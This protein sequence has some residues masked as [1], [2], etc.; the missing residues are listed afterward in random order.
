[1]AALALCAVAQGAQAQSPAEQPAP[2]EWSS[3]SRAKVT[4][5]LDAAGPMASD[6]SS[7]AAVPKWAD[8][9]LPPPPGARQAG[10]SGAAASGM[11]AAG[12]LAQNSSAPPP[13]Q[14]AAGEPQVK[15]AVDQTGAMI[16]VRQDLD[17]DKIRQ[18]WAATGGTIPAFE[19]NGGMTILYK[20]MS[21]Q[22]GAGAYMSGVGFNFGGRVT[23]LM[24][25]PPKYE[26]RDRD[27]T[28]WKVGGGID[29]GVLTSTF[30]LPA[31]RYTPAMTSRSSVSTMTLVGTIGF[32]HAFGS[33]DSPTEW[34]GFAIGADWAPSYQ[35]MSMTDSNSGQVTTSSSFNATGF[36]INFESGSMRSMAAKMGKKAHM[37]L[38][39]FFLP[40]TGQLPFLMTA[41]LG[42]VW[43]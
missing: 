1:M 13:S 2:V 43:Y 7:V 28:A 14:G 18:D 31:T 16:S 8:V 42:A 11:G 36:A 34:S 20:D 26:T 19:A 15:A 39:L 9:P 24:L 4:K 10:A 40:P 17:S 27:W 22:I 41:S 30:N 5:P 12:L 6:L 37:K 25:D 21:Q 32:M 38:S 35:S 33:F 23:M 3:M 29:L